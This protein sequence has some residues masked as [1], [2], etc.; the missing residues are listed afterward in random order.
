[1]SVVIR[2]PD[3]KMQVLNSTLTSVNTRYLRIGILVSGLALCVVKQTRRKE[4]I[5]TWLRLPFCT[6]S[7]DQ[8]LL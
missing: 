7:R 5:Q 1:M 8:D 2:Y 6:L 3:T 4:L